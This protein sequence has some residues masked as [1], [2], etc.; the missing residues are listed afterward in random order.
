MVC[1]CNQSK[2]CKSQ[3]SFC[4]I[5][6]EE[7]ADGKR[8]FGQRFFMKTYVNFFFLSKNSSLLILLDSNPTR[9]F[10]WNHDSCTEHGL[11][12]RPT[13]C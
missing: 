10:S 8:L 1:G 13:T 12:T 2:A 6:D 9:S 5:F 7:L 3:N 11:I 4:S